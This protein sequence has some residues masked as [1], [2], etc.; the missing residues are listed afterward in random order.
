MFTTLSTGT[1]AASAFV[2]GAA[3]TPTDQRILYDS[4]TGGLFHN[5]DG[6]GVHRSGGFCHPRHGPG[7]H[8]QLLLGDLSRVGGLPCR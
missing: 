8:Q 3:A 1:L 6:S 5:S 2:I 4:A 7:A